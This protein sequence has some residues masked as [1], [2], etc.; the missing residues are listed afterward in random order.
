MEFD[1]ED[2]LRGSIWVPDGVLAAY[3]KLKVRGHRI[4]KYS[5]SGMN[6]SA[7]ALVRSAIA[8]H[9]GTDAANAVKVEWP[10]FFCAASLSNGCGVVSDFTV[11]HLGKNVRLSGFYGCDVSPETVVDARWN[12]WARAMLAVGVAVAR[13]LPS[14]KR[15]VKRRVLPSYRRY[16]RLLLA[17]IAQLRERLDASAV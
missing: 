12:E 4:L 3:V 8:T 16:R 13:R 10:L 9:R 2:W 5:A 14:E 11:E 6:N 7:I 1:T 15:G 17:D